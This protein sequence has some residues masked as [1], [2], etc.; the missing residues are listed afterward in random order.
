M[1]DTT[2]VSRERLLGDLPTSPFHQKDVTSVFRKVTTKLPADT[3]L[4]AG[5]L[6]RWPKLASGRA[7]VGFVEEPAGR[8]VS[9]IAASPQLDINYNV[10]THGPHLQVRD[11]GHTTGSL[12]APHQCA[13]TADA[14]RLWPR[15]CPLPRENR[16]GRVSRDAGHRLRRSMR[17][18]DC[19][20]HPSFPLF[21]ASGPARCSL[22]APWLPR[23]GLQSYVPCFL[24]FLYL[25]GFCKPV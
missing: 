1:R 4:H 5:Q 14:Q 19:F 6:T 10:L 2:Q 11:P 12:V 25:P 20:L 16:T 9:W 7:G 17:A 3:T 22:N 18:S 8:F 21:G 15:T 23:P 13:G 24:L